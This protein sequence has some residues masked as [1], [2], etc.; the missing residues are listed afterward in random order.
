MSDVERVLDG[1]GISAL[2]HGWMYRDLGRWDRLRQL[3]HPNATIEV[4][5]F[6]GGIDEFLD[7]SRGMARSA[8]RNKHLIGEPVLDVVGDRAFAM[9]N[10]VVVSENREVGLGCDSHA[11][12]LDR[13]E[14]RDGAWRILHRAV[15]YDMATFTFPFG[16]AEIDAAAVD[17]HPREYAALGYVLERSG[18]RI[19]RAMPTRGSAAEETIRKRSEEWLGGQ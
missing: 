5:W 7:R 3:F 18:F 9:T 10:I 15:S 16:L 12:F 14:R 11:R 17:R 1:Y 19:E 8:F 2:M 6:S 4:S 13:V